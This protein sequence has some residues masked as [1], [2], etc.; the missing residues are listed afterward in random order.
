[1]K[2]KN[3]FL[4]LVLVMVFR[5]SPAQ[6]VTVAVGDFIYKLNTESLIAKIVGHT[7]EPVGAV[8]LDN[9]IYDGNTYT[10]TEIGDSVFF[11]GGSG[12]SYQYRF[13]QMTSLHCPNVV[14]IGNYVLSGRDGLRPIFDEMTSISFPKVTK[15]GHYVFYN[16]SGQIFRQVRTL[17]FPELQEIGDY[18][19]HSFSSS[20]YAT[21]GNFSFE[22]MTSFFWPKLTTVGNN[23]FVMTFRYLNSLSLPKLM[24]VGNN[25]FSFRFFLL[26]RLSLP[27]LKETGDDSFKFCVGGQFE[28]NKIVLDLPELVKCGRGSFLD[29]GALKTINLPKLTKIASRS[30][31]VHEIAE[32]QASIEYKEIGGGCFVTSIHF[33]NVTEIGDSV[34]WG[35]LG[36]GKIRNLYTRLESINL[37][38]VT[39]I[40]KR[41]F[42]SNESFVSVK[43]I[44]MPNIKEIGDSSFFSSYKNAGAESSYANPNGYHSF[45]CLDSV[46]I[47]MD[48]KVGNFSIVGRGRPVYFLID[49]DSIYTPGSNSF[50]MRFD[51]FIVPTGKAHMLIEKWIM[52]ASMPNYRHEVYSPIPMKKSHSNYNTMTVALESPAASFTYGGEATYDRNNYNF[53]YA[54][55]KSDVGKP[56]RNYTSPEIFRGTDYK[57]KWFVATAYDDV[58][59]KEGVLTITSPSTEVSRFGIAPGDGF[60]LKGP[61]FTGEGEDIIYAPVHTNRNKY[62]DTNYFKAGTGAVVAK[63][64]DGCWNF[65]FSASKQAFYQC[66]NTVIPKD[67]A[68]LALPSE[69]TANAKQISFVIDDGESEVTGIVSLTPDPSPE[70]EGD[71]YSLDGRKLDGKPTTKGIYIHNG[72]KE[73]IK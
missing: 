57:Y 27:S 48:V 39:K 52:N 6:T 31:G 51:R 17:Y 5:I 22:G 43:S 45:E 30:F 64:S 34:F 49:A 58:G 10:I 66:N 61:A 72:R 14:T 56:M 36:D 69:M 42:H 28:E 1:M 35:K 12:L 13:N 8:V 71:Y 55:I 33:P 16:P 11:A 38:K 50:S 62:T 53:N 19:L 41:S 7:A 20:R 3:L 25:S 46:I 21:S 37:P 24:T 65:Y 68:Y 15:I 29:M 44:N 67:R 47:P 63:E 60:L 26:T 59:D 54:L 9:V 23:S 40:G 4:T 73:V 18:V 2:R 70:G 32:Q